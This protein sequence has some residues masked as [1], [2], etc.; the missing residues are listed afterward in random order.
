MIIITME[1]I[2]STIKK[3]C[4]SPQ[5]TGT[6]RHDDNDNDYDDDCDNVDGD[7]GDDDDDDDGGGGK[8]RFI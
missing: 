8:L 7:Y 2:F 5:L 1:E 4:Q 3:F 6:N